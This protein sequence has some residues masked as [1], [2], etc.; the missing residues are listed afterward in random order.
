MGDGGGAGVTASD[1]A[2]D[3]DP[4]RAGLSMLDLFSGLGGFSL[5]AD[6]LGID[7]IAFCECEP[8]PTRVQIGR[9]SCRERV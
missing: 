8:Y 9:A 7:T 4:P 1:I 3:H 2:H 5:A 6:S